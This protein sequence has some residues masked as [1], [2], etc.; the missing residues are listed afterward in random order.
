MRMSIN[1]KH[2]VKLHFGLK[3][4]KSQS[5]FVVCLILLFYMKLV[6]TIPQGNWYCNIIFETKLTVIPKTTLALE[7]AG[8]SRN[9]ETSLKDS[10]V[11][12]HTQIPRITSSSKSDQIF[13]HSKYQDARFAF[14]NYDSLDI[15]LK[16]RDANP[17]LKSGYIECN[18]EYPEILH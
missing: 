9:F 5:S 2:R 15:H 6:L 11:D 16:I 17:F 10:R 1:D 13:F 18:Q 3:F 7:I 14:T 4:H 8:I 12:F